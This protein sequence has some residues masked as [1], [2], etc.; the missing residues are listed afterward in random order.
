MNRADHVRSGIGT[1]SPDSLRTGK[2]SAEISPGGVLSRC[3]TELRDQVVERSRQFVDVDARPVG[4]H[5]ARF[6]IDPDHGQLGE[7]PEQPRTERRNISP[8]VAQR[9]DGDDRVVGVE[10]FPAQQQAQPRCDGDLIRGFRHDVHIVMAT[11]FGR[12]QILIEPLF[13]RQ[14]DVDGCQSVSPGLSDQFG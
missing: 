10:R 9:H 7:F 4:A 1:S 13:D 11:Q 12:K 5:Q 2:G 14:D 8:G 3:R 6:P